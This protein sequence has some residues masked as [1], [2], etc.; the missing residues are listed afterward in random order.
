MINQL[1]QHFEQMGFVKE[2]CDLVERC[3]KT[4][5]GVTVMVLFCDSDR[6]LLMFVYDNKIVH[7]FEIKDKEVLSLTEPQIVRMTE[8]AFLKK[9]KVDGHEL[10]I[11][12][13]RE[14]LSKDKKE[15][16]KQFANIIKNG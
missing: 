15:F 9:L 12:S 11:K 1:M 4:F 8:V 10:A 7:K 14:Q 16:K 3:T 6:T 5:D 13:H 2:K